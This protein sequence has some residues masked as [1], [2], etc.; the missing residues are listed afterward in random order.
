MVG[1]AATADAPDLLERCLHEAFD[2]VLALSAAD[3]SAET[4]EA[5]S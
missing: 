5:R 2:E 4:K 3:H 1:M